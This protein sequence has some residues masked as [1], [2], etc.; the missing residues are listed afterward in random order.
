MAIQMRRGAKKDFNPD[1]L[2]VGEFAVPTDTNEVY[3]KTSENITKGIA[4][5]D[6]NGK[7]SNDYLNNECINTDKLS[8]LSVTSD[9]LS[10]DSVSTNKLIDNSVTT[11][12]LSN[13]SVTLDKI[14]DNSISTSKLINNSITTEKIED[15]SVTTD[16]LS[17]ASVSTNKLINNAITTAKIADGSVTTSKIADGSVTTGKLASGASIDKWKNWKH[18]DGISEL[19]LDTTACTL[20]DIC[21]AMVGKSRMTFA[22]TFTNYT[23]LVSELPWNR[24]QLI[25]QKYDSWNCHL[26]F[27]AED[28]PGNTKLYTV[29]RWIG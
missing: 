15:L 23:T 17:D 10:D 14:S 1:K 4:T 2:K 27:Y 26:E 21:S 6:D 29:K 28:L 12:K 3:I 18:Y 20:N 13:L 5:L 9:K 8:D 24:G 16:K 25:I 7:I 11:A 22:A 19:N